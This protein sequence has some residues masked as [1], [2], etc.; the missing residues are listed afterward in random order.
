MKWAITDKCRHYLLGADFVVLTDNNPLV[1]F[2]TAPLGALE[3]RWTSQLAQFNFQIQYRPGKTNPADVLSRMP[4]DL[5]PSSTA[6]PPGIAAAQDMCCGQQSVGTPSVTSTDDGPSAAQPQ[7]DSL[8]PRLSADQLSDLQRQDS[9]IGPVLAAWPAK[10]PRGPGRQLRALTQQHARL[11]QK[12]GVLYRRVTD[13]THGPCEQLVLPSSLRPDVLAALHDHMGHQGYD[14][15]IDLLR[16]RVYWPGMY[17]ETKQYVANCP[18][19][20]MNRLP[21]LLDTT[22]TPLLASRPLQVLAI[23]LTKLEPASDNRDNVLVLT[24]VFTKLSQA[25]PTR[26][27]EAVTVATV[28][29]KEW[30]QRYGVP[31]QIHS[32]QGRDFVYGTHPKLCHVKDPTS[33]C[34]KRVGLGLTACG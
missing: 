20:T 29:V 23:D 2:R 19:C 28:L 21:T 15:T 14:R 30:F 33:I 5:P 24:D 31:A 4:P 11:F 18:R 26:N 34:R 3:Q 25:I 16:A 13:S 17:G 9:T 1:H 12:D 27:Q 32:D 7:Q 8:F 22:S 6:M 10:P